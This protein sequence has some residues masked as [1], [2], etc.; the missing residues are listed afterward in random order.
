MRKFWTKEVKVA[1]LVVSALVVLYIGLNYLK[2]INLFSNTKYYYA[3]YDDLGGLVISNPVYI[4]GYKIGQVSAVKYDFTHEQPFVVELSVAGDIV[5]PKGTIVELF[6]DGLLGGKAVRLALGKEAEHFANGDTLLSA[7]AEGLMA[8]LERDLLP[9]ITQT[10]NDAD[11]LI[12]EAKGLMASPEIKRSLQSIDGATHDLRSTAAKLNN[13]MDNKVPAVLADVDSIASDF[14]TV[15]G[16]LKQ[17][18]YVEI[19]AKMDSTMD[20]IHSLSERLNDEN[21]TLGLLLN[22]KRLYNDID[23]TVNSANI[24][25]QDLKAHP[26]RYVHFSVFG[27]KE[28]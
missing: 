26:K 4:N 8:S 19:V 10:V 13:I 21:S 20:N 27:K 6:D 3:K 1:L 5:L 22:D 11:S 18:N 24:L 2:G 14:K 25:L 28:K 7:T 17:V 15:S 12:L 9:K 16:E 23:S